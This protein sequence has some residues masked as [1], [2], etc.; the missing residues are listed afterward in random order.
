[1]TGANKLFDRISRLP[2]WLMAPDPKNL[3]ALALELSD[4]SPV[5]RPVRLDLLSPPGGV[6]RGPGAVFGAPVPEA[7]IHEHRDTLSRKND[8]GMAPDAWYGPT[9]Y[10]VAETSAVEFSPKRQFS[11]SVLLTRRLHPAT[12]VLR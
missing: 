3:P 10:S 8:V 2:S 9:M 1:M 12:H 6:R 7:P 11:R 5:P 4:D